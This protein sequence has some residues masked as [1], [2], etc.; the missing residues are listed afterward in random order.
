MIYSCACTLT[1]SRTVALLPRSCC[2][3]ATVKTARSRSG[4]CRT[5]RP[6]HPNGSTRS[7]PPCGATRS[8]AQ[9]S[10]RSY[11]AGRR[12]RCRRVGHGAEARLGHL[13]GHEAFAPT[14]PLHGDDRGSRPQSPGLAS[15]TAA[16]SRSTSTARCTYSSASCTT[17]PRV[18]A[19]RRWTPPSP[20]GGGRL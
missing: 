2:A 7:R 5:C 20:C 18:R 11:G 6:G 4:P 19:T 12:E 1:S 15:S 14:R 17:P 9:R 8:R 3:K 16:I 10:W 13:S